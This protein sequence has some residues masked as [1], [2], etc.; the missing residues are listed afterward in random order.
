MSGIKTVYLFPMFSGL[1]Q[2]LAVRLTTA[3]CSKWLSI[4]EMRMR[5]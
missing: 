3:S 1:D 2:Y 4:R 5:S